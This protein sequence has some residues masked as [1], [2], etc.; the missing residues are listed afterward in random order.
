MMRNLEHC[1]IRI[2]C[3]S[4]RDPKARGKFVGTSTP[5]LRVAPLSTSSVRYYNIQSLCLVRLVEMAVR[6][7]SA[8]G[9]GIRAFIAVFDEAP[10]MDGDGSLRW[11]Q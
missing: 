5:P 9:A 8:T 2:A 3:W 6:M 10:C 11:K 7:P 4:F 1:F